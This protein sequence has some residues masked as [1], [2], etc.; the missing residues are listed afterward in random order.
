[1]PKRLALLLAICCITSV[2][3]QPPAGRAD[4]VYQTIRKNDLVRLKAI[5]RAAADANAKIEGGDPL[6]MTAAGAGSVDAMRLLLDKG[7]DVNATNA[8]GATALIWSATDIAKT[9]LLLERGANVN[10]AGKSGRTALFV[11]AM[12]DPSADIVKLLIAK[13][14]DVK[15][16][17]AFGNTMLGAAAVGNDLNT[18]RIM[19]DAGIDVNGAGINGV[20]PLM[21]VAYY[22]N[23]AAATLLIGR[24]AKVNV[25]CKAPLMLPIE[26]PKSGPL[27]L[28]NITPLMIAAV[29]GSSDLVKLFVDAGADVNATDVRKMTPLMLAVARNRQ[30]PAIIRLLIDRGSDLTLQS[31]AGETAADWARKVGRPAGVEILKVTTAAERRAGDKPVPAVDARA[32]AERS[33][34]LLETSS[35][36]FYE[37]SGCIS[38]HHQNITDL[39]AAEARAKGIKISTDAAMGRMKMLSTE[40]PPQPLYERMDIGVPEIFAQQLTSFAALD[41]PPNPATDALVADIAATQSAD[42]SWFASGGVNDRPPA[43][44]GRI[45]RTALCIRALKVYGS[46]GRAIEMKA[47]VANARRWLLAAE[48]V[49][50]EERNM[51]LLGIYWAGADSVTLKKLAAPILAAQQPDGG[52]HQQDRLASDA[53]ATG[54]SL[55]VLAKVGALAPGAPAYAK[56]VAFLMSTQ[57][58]NGSW[59][60]TSRSPKFQAYFN[61]GFPYAGDQWISAWATGW[62]TM[63]LAQAVR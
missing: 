45:T 4:D 56:G 43:E 21:S 30:D 61:S 60:V 16:K 11:A 53:Y 44:E 47:R 22:N 20:T 31:G 39:A 42:G 46:P 6:L 37:T 52:W 48:P 3:A 8:F 26:N 12:S 51:Q 59:R 17:D 40:P 33:M 13:G 24:G 58:A 41:V 29:A 38:C 50:S 19:V 62:A 15:A 32:A 2:A 14:A 1:M 28:E 49:T 5:V 9:R 10:A 55:Y 23:V 63:A 7:A 54:Q 25:A 36:K 34:A 35:R 27:T 57:A 18:I